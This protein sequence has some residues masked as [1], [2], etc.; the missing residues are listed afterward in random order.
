MSEETESEVG[1]VLS[2]AGHLK[3][4]FGGPLAAIILLSALSTVR[5]RPGIVALVISGGA[6]VAAGL[7]VWLKL[8]A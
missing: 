2:H 6:L 5:K 1:I 8:K 7:H 4:E 3:K